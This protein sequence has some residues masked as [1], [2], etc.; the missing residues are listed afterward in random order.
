MKVSK[1]LSLETAAVRRGEWYSKRHQTNLSRLVSD[2]L[3]RLPVD[4]STRPLSPT[5][6]RLLGIVG[7]SEQS[8]R[9][10][11]TYHEH[12][13]TKYGQTGRA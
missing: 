6:S 7:N 2:F 4:E 13:W 10:E 5:V 8:E 11:E 1:N 3:L 9:N 12:L